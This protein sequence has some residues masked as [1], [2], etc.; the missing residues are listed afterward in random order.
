MEL[1]LFKYNNTALAVKI[2]FKSYT[3]GNPKGTST[4]P[5]PTGKTRYALSLLADVD[6][7][8]FLDHRVTI[9]GVPVGD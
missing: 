7:N 1:S 6:L 4:V 5:L 2:I 3:E 8:L 9:G